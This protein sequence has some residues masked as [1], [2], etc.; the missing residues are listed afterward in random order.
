MYYI[1]IL[2]ELNIKEDINFKFQKKEVIKHIVQKYVNN[3]IA[4]F[5]RFM[6]ILSSF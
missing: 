5:A 1:K 4:I 6:T 2:T 3:R